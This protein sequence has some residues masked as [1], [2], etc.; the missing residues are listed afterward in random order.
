MNAAVHLS[1]VH[2]R[3]GILRPY[4]RPTVV[5][6]IA[7]RETVTKT[8]AYIIIYAV[9]KLTIGVYGPIFFGG[10]RKGGI[11]R[12]SVYVVYLDNRVSFKIV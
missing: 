9:P 8:T 11:D 10:G 4:D 6:L 1:N 7:R 2:C 3:S 12:S 5:A